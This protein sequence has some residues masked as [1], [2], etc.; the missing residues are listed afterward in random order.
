MTKSVTISNKFDLKAFRILL[1]KE[2][3]NSSLI[4]GGNLSVGFANDL[5]VSV[6]PAVG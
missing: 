6:K 5:K 3:G 4:M 2:L 1:L